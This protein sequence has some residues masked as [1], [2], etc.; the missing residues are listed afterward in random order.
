MSLNKFSQGAIL[1]L[2]SVILNTI[3]GL[4]ILRFTISNLLFNLFKISIVLVFF[5][6][7]SYFIGEA[8]SKIEE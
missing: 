7:I 6:I 8:L 2:V 4:I 3:G 1:I 5:I